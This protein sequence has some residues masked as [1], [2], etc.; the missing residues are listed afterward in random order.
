MNAANAHSY[1]FKDKDMTMK[2]VLGGLDK[3]AAEKLYTD[4]KYGMDT[5]TKLYY[6]AK[7]TAGSADP[8]YQ[9]LK[10]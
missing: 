9:L 2:A 8:T 3:D 1:I 10:K 4:E 6:W 7:A 5:A